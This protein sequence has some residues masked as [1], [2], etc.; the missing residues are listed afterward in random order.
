[1]PLR[2][3]VRNSTWKG[4]WREWREA[5]GAYNLLIFYTYSLRFSSTSL[6]KKNRFLELLEHGGAAGHIH[7]DEGVIYPLFFLGE[8]EREITVT[9]PN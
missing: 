5:A 9:D 3:A 8:V 6:L 7:G 1:M 2:S 4:L